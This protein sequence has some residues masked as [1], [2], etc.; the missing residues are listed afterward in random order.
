MRA[1]NPWT[2]GSGWPFM[3]MAT[4]ASR[5]S[6]TAASGVPAVN[7]S[8]LVDSRA[9]ASSCTPA[10]SSSSDRSTPSQV[11]LPARSPP[12]GLDTHVSVIR[13]STSRR[14]SRS[15]KVT[16]ISLSTIPWMRRLHEPA[17]TS[18]GLRA[19]SIR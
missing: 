16:S 4:M 6:V 17:G 15:V 2:M 18:G 5:P 7:P 1:G 8:A 14:L 13:R 11:A 10:S 12:T 3:P 19:V 9:S